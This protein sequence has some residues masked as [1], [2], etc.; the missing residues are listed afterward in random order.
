M[1]LPE[2]LAR[3]GL[4]GRGTGRRSA[5][6]LL[7]AAGLQTSG[8]VLIFLW[9]FALV[10]THSLQT[11]HTILST[12]SPLKAQSYD[13]VYKCIK[14]SVLLGSISGTQPSGA[15]GG[16][17]G[18]GGEGHELARPPPARTASDPAR[19]ASARQQ[20]PNH[21]PWGRSHT[22]VSPVSYRL[23]FPKQLFLV[24]SVFFTLQKRKRG[25]EALTDLLQP[26][27]YRGHGGGTQT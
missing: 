4:A 9:S 20:V 6:R 11:L 13:Y 7:C 19:P 16:R 15:A 18:G 27:R 12:G 14:S 26:P 24:D 8:L 10:E 2:Q 1:C 23:T 25:S 21:C 17:P 22:Y 3:P 5:T